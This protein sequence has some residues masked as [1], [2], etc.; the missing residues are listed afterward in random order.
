MFLAK[1][2]PQETIRFHTDRL[3]ENYYLLRSSYGKNFIHMDDRM[4]QLLKWAVEYHDIGKADTRFQN[5][6]RKKLKL[7]QLT[8]VHNCHVPHNYLSV[9]LIPFSQLGV[10]EEEIRLLVQTVG[11]HHERQ[12]ILNQK[13]KNDVKE[14]IKKDIFP[15][16]DDLAEH[17]GIP[18]IEKMTFG[19][20]DWLHKRYNWGTTEKEQISFLRYVMIKGLL[21]RLDHAASA[22]VFVE[23]GIKHNVGKSVNSFFKKKNFAKRDLQKYAEKNMNNH[24]IIMA[25]TGMG[26]TEAGLLWINNTKGFFTLP[27]RVSINAMYNRASDPNGINISPGKGAVGLLHSSSLDY[28]GQEDEGV[29]WEI[30]YN[31]SRQLANKLLIT[32]IDQILKFPFYYLGFEKEY[33]ALAGTKIVIDE[34]QSYDPKIAALIIRALEMVDAIGG[35]FMVITATMPKL[36]LD[37]I[38]QESKIKRPIKC[39]T[40][41]DDSLERHR[42]KIM[43]CPINEYIDEM[44]NAGQ[45]KK[46]LVICNTV[47]EA[48]NV[49][50]NLKNVDAPVRML[51]ALFIQKDRFRLEDEIKKFAESV[52]N[53]IWVTTQLV[54]AS[55][56]ID[57]DALYTEMSVLDSLFQRLG[58]CYR[59]R[60]L[61]SDYPNVWVFTGNVSGVPYVY[62]KE[63]I[64]KSIDLLQDYDCKLILE[65][66]KMQLIKNLYHPDNLQGTKFI[67]VFEK[68][69]SYLQTLDPYD[70]DRKKA[71]RYLRDI[72][73]IRVIPRGIFDSINDSLIVGF[74]K[75][76]D[77][78]K[79]RQLRRKINQY[80]LGINKYRAKTL[81]SYDEL[82]RNLRDVAII[83]LEYDFDGEIG[84]GL[85]L[86]RSLSP[87]S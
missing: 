5:K 85:L 39:Q 9:V 79:R 69:L 67:N 43:D 26:K 18:M 84:K 47:K 48:T 75:E 72:Q 23:Q 73:Q 76:K 22:N 45:D 50:E 74:N 87:F 42:I 4:W 56:D 3:L 54:E 66:K 38:L 53:G 77:Q 52:N 8:E 37:Y 16:I 55:L 44:A 71:Q 80:T 57:F 29:N 33:S 81:V 59:Q 61:N 86:N 19:S 13:L 15:G 70:M 7:P 58:R 78:R 31:H 34:M 6:L 60:K 41:I 27:L 20:F 14:I 82:P 35:Q 1:S 30:Y 2:K 25:Q 65:S 36:Y 28:L 21:H 17:M 12:I 49:Y 64:E 11:Y 62:D 40:F 83:D 46:V 63:L 68:T 24:L 32:T 10:N 51:H